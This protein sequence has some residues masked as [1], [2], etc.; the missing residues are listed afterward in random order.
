ML[1]KM[2]DNE[3]DDN[4]DGE[5]LTPADHGKVPG[6]GKTVVPVPAMGNWV[7]GTQWAMGNGQLAMGTQWATGNGRQYLAEP[8]VVMQVW[9]AV[10]MSN[11]SFD[12]RS[13][14]LKMDLHIWIYFSNYLLV[15]TQWNKRKT[16]C[17]HQDGNQYLVLW[18]ECVPCMGDIEVG[19]RVNGT[20][21][22]MRVAAVACNHPNHR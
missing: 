10:K 14:C 7:I 22:L 1:C 5:P 6:N 8:N 16:R 4:D 19:G 11:I 12:L 15:S 9:L 17:L 13:C 21:G 2:I 3:S 20:G 18:M